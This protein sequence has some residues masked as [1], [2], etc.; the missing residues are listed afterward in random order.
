MTSKAAIAV[1]QVLFFPMGVLGGLVM[2]PEL[3]PEF[4]QDISPYV[5]TRGVAELLWAVTVGSA[6]DTVALV[7]LGV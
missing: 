6:P 2:P 7:M 1:S 3:L 5:P 4:V